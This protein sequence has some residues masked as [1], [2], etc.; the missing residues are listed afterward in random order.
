[1]CSSIYQEGLRL[2]I[3]RLMKAD[4]L[5][6]DILDIIKLNSRTPDER[7]GDLQA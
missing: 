5:Q 1:M 6:T 7:L 2:P 3:V 4:V